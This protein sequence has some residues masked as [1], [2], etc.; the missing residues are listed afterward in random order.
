MKNV[1]GFSFGVVVGLLGAGFFLAPCAQAEP[2]IAAQ[3]GYVETN[4]ATN[5]QGKGLNTGAQYSDL[6]LKDTYLYGARA[7]YFFGEPQDNIFGIEFEANNTNPSVNQQTTVSS[8]TGPLQINGNRLRVTTLALNVVA[9]TPRF[10]KFQPYAGV[11]PGLFL[12]RD[13]S[14]AGSHPFGQ[15]T[16][17]GLNGFAGLRFF[18]TDRLALFGEY[19]YNLAKMHF[20]NFFGA[21]ESGVRFNYSS[22]IVLVGLA[23]HF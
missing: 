21:T 5:V 11:G 18:V 14:P 6:T 3:G 1:T 2:Y 17:V 7:G 16:T 15:S 20:E 9:R 22:N 23:Y 8:Q 13:S 4:N 19:K 10:G 12:A